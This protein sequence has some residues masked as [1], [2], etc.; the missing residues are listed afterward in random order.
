MNQDLVNKV[1]L[2]ALKLK[3]TSLSEIEIKERLTHMGFPE[4]ISANAAKDIMYER[5]K[6]SNQ[7]GMEGIILGVAIMLLGILVSIGF[8]L[9][10]EEK[11]FFDIGI[12]AT[13]AGILIR[14]LVR[15]YSK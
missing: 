6:V 9:F 15:R 13:G 4:E 1:Y 7:A 5:G 11:I 2:E 3:K 12:I 8:T 14:G 10:S